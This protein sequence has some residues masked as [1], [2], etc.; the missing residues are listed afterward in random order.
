MKAIMI[1]LLVCAALLISASAQGQHP[2]A[3]H[4]C[5]NEIKTT[6]ENGF[7]DEFVELFNLSDSLFSMAGYALLYFDR[8][9][10]ALPESLIVLPDG[11]T[12]RVL[13]SVSRFPLHQAFPLLPAGRSALCRSRHARCAHERRSFLKWSTHSGQH[14]HDGYA[15]CRG[16]GQDRCA[17]DQ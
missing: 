12:Y 13:V 1:L 9:G 3:N 6:G 8:F 7:L 17:P 11:K 4:I 2:A 16:L 14:E 5:I 10:E 15:R